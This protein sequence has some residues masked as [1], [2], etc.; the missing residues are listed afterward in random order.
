[1]DGRSSK[2]CRACST[3]TTLSAWAQPWPV[4]QSSC[5]Q[6]RHGAGLLST[7][8]SCRLAGAQRCASPPLDTI[9]LGT[10]SAAAMCDTPVSL[11]IR[12][13]APAI[14]APSGHSPVR[15]TRFTQRV[16]MADAISAPSA[17]SCGLPVST[18]V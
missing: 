2:S 12:Q 7:R 1:M 16:C 15:P 18:T 13:R 4:G 17:C 11:L 3:S 9:R 8:C 5:A 10:A 14:N 6:G